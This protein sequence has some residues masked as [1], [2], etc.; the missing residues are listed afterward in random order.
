MATHN[1]LAY[2]L[3]CVSSEDSL[4]NVTDAFGEKGGKVAVLLSPEGKD[5][6]KDVEVIA[7][8]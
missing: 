8:T 5:I 2:A 4:K 7:M 1:D 3:D 6:R